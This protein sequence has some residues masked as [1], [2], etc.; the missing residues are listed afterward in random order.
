MCCG[1]REYFLRSEQ[2]QPIVQ[3]QGLP[4]M[5]VVWGPG[6]IVQQKLQQQSAAQAPA[7]DLELGKALGQ[8]RAPDVVH[9]DEAGILM[10]RE[11]R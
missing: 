2:V 3:I 4:D 10:A 5:N 9:P 11:K 6:Q 7:L 8:I 1:T